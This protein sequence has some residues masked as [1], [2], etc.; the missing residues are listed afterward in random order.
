MRNKININH[1]QDVKIL[2]ELYPPYTTIRLV[3]MYDNFAP[4][5]GTVGTITN[6]DD[7]GTIHVKWKNGSSLGLIHSLDSYFL[8]FHF[9][10]PLNLYLPFSGKRRR[11]IGR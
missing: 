5:A 9:L 10:T 3:K 1:L 11:C 2:R 6:V 8:L 4:A 7:A